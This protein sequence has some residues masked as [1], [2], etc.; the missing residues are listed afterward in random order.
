MKNSAIQLASG[1]AAQVDPTNKSLINRKPNVQLFAFLLLLSSFFSPFFVRLY[2]THSRGYRKEN[3][4][5][6]IML[7]L[8]DA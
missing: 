1:I 7:N 4:I 2:L 8:D 6:R 5:Q 3:Q